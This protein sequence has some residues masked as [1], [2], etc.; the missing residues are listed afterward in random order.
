MD[1][2]FNLKKEENGIVFVNKYENIFLLLE[3]MGI[4]FVYIYVL[5]ED[6]LL[7]LWMV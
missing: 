3:Y 5:F 1:W 2:F 6:V 4:I 7:I